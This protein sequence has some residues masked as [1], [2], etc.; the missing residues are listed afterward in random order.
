M[1]VFIIYLWNA[2]HQVDY[3][4]T[5]VN[6]LCLPWSRLACVCVWERKR[7]RDRSL[8]VCVFVRVCKRERVCVFVCVRCETRMK[9]SHLKRKRFEKKNYHAVKCFAFHVYVVLLCNVL[10]IILFQHQIK[11]Y[12]HQLKLFWT[13]FS[14]YQIN[15]TL[16]QNQ[17]NFEPILKHNLHQK[18]WF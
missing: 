18:C 1:T 16:Y 3:V 8:C 11:S 9:I 2:K 6:F 14:L 7:E 15:Q 12:L 5:R 4:C 17:I 13:N 10:E